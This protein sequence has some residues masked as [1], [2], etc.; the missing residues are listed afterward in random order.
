MTS[1]NSS[2]RSNSFVFVDDDPRVR[3]ALKAELADIGV[4]ALI[5]A[6]PFELFDNPKVLASSVIFLD[7]ILPTMSGIDC[8]ERLRGSGFEG[9]IV[10]VTALCDPAMREQVLAAGANDFIIKSDFF[11][12]LETV[13][14]K[15]SV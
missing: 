2:T 4:S 1:S 11:D 5:L 7:L 8:V 10:V 3:D 13:L 15:Y 12:S 14:G 6:N 9:F